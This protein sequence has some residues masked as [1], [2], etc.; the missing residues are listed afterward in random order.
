VPS[1]DTVPRLPWSTFDPGGDGHLER[2]IVARV[3]LLPDW[4]L[5][6]PAAALIE[7]TLS[8]REAGLEP[9]PAAS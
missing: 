4:Y 2:F 8:D 6:A 7:W 5:M 9:T 1:F 3:V